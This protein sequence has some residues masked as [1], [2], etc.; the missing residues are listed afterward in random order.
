MYVYIS[1]SIPESTI[2]SQRKK[3]HDLIAA[4]IS[5]LKF[6]SRGA[7]MCLTKQSCQLHDVLTLDTLMERKSPQKCRNF[8]M[9]QIYV[10]RV[11]LLC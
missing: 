3:N 5:R 10:N 6:E 2:M 4:R 1:H 9:S 7:G 11:I 8:Q